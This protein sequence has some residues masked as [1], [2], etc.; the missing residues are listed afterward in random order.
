MPRRFFSTSH[1]VPFPLAG[2][3]VMI[4]TSVPL[5]SGLETRAK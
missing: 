1:W 5:T 3:P 4:T 2:G